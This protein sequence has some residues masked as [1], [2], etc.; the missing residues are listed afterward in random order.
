[1]GSACGLLH[2][3]ACLD[4]KGMQKSVTNLNRPVKDGKRVIERMTSPG[5]VLLIF[6][7][8]FSSHRCLTVDIEKI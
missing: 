3:R 8:F 6:F 7:T 5:I 4:S 2:A 1:M